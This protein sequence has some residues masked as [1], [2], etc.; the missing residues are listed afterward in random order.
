MFPCVPLLFNVNLWSKIN[1]NLDLKA[2]TQD[3]LALSFFFYFSSL[4]ICTLECF[5]AVGWATGRT[6]SL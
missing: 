1:N 2:V 6:S 5:D 3:F 4:H